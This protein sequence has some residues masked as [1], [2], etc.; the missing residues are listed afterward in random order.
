MFLLVSSICGLLASVLLYLTPR[1]KRNTLIK[2]AIYEVRYST[3]GVKD[4]FSQ[5]MNRKAEQIKFSCKPGKI[6]VVTGGSRGIG[7]AVA[8]KLLE[9]DMEVI[10]A[11]RTP[12][13][14]EKAISQIRQSGVKTGR[15]KVYK[16]DNASLESVK[17]FAKQVKKD[18]DKIH[19][20]INNAGIMFVPY[21][22]TKD[23]YEQQW[24][25]NYLSHFLLTSLLL[26]QLR[27][28]SLNGECSRVINVTSCA[29]VL[30]S[31][32]FNDINQKD[33]FVTSAA[34]AQSKLAQVLFT[35][36]LQY[37]LNEKKLNVKVYAVHP[38]IVDTDLFM[39]SYVRHFKLLFSYITK[40][41][42]EGALSILYAAMSKDIKERGGLYIANC[43]EN[44]DDPQVIDSI[45]QEQLFKLTLEHVALKDFFQFL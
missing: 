21:N 18:Y 10:I 44:S 12:S 1:E 29:H 36:R 34:Y 16:L 5:K 14:G 3:L 39:H 31:I 9:L 2:R 33:Q 28:G 40:T 24:G 41:P 4:A 13:A 30:G 26:P 6:A 35:K 25:V 22:E 45:I 32:N 42:E 11:C 43:Q 8:K 38:G 23:G 15:A 20:L 27:N 19:L 7:A 37:L 17:E